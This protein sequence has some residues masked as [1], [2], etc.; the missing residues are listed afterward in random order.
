MT[1]SLAL[2][3]F[4]PSDANAIST[5]NF[6]SHGVRW[7]VWTFLARPTAS[8]PPPDTHVVMVLAVFS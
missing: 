2:S 7:S 5:E 3:R 8:I 6:G 4:I 1:I